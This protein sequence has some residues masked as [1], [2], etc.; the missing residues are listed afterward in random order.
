MGMDYRR[1]IQ[2]RMTTLR[3]EIGA[4]LSERQAVDEHRKASDEEVDAR[5][6]ELE[7][8]EA[9]YPE[10]T[11]GGG[12]MSAPPQTSPETDRE[13]L[14]ALY[15]ATDGPHWVI[16]SNWLSD[17]PIGEWHGVTTNARGK[18]E[19]LN[20]SFNQL[21]GEIPRELG[22][23]SGVRTLDLSFNQLSGEIPRELGN[24]SA[25]GFLFLNSNQLSGEIPQ[26]LGNLSRLQ[27]LHLYGNQLSGCIPGN[28]ERWLDISSSDL[29]CLPFCPE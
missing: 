25:L 16:N 18:L 12:G 2:E 23:L 5:Q 27:M 6:R 24:L 22:N 4:K 28:L 1:I 21:S 15:H 17:L 8:L 29:G 26:E 3:Q 9:A 20:L 13:S 14:I 10:L 11:F 7:H 19:S